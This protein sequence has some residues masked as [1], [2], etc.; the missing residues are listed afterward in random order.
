LNENGTGMGW[1]RKKME[2][3]KTEN[4]ESQTKRLNLHSMQIKGEICH[5]WLMNIRLMERHVSGP[6]CSAQQLS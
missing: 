1:Y 6:F 5:N 2:T 3:E 4:L